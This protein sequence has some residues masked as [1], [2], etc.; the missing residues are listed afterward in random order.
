[1]DNT[2]QN[3]KKADNTLLD[4]KAK[5]NKIDDE[6]SSVS[7]QKK[8]LEN[9]KDSFI[10]LNKSIDDCYSLLAASFKGKKV[11]SFFTNNSLENNRR[12]KKLTENIDNNTDI[13][14]KKLNNLN[15]EKEKIQ[16]EKREE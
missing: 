13:L 5:I 8:A 11:N 1:M 16:K 3:Q 7:N 9:I 12:L 6:I 2:N 10:D 4:N 14:Q 15:D